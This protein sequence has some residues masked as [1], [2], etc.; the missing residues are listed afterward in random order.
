MS[1]ISVDNVEV[2]KAREGR[3]W[4]EGG[5]MSKDDRGELMKKIRR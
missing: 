2:V 5:G 3:G 1:K 4:D